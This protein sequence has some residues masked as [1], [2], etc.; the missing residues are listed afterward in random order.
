MLAVIGGTGFADFTGLEDIESLDVENAWG[1]ARLLR[2]RLEGERLLFLPRHGIPPMT[3]PHKINYRANIQALADAG[4]TKVVS[5]TAVGSVDA[6]LEVPHLVIPDQI[7][8]YTWGRSQ[9]FYD[10]EIQHIDFTFP[11]DPG[12]RGR[13]LEAAAELGAEQPD[14]PCRT[15]GVYGCTQGPRLET[16]A[17]IRRLRADGCDIVGMTAMPEAALARER[18]LPYAAMSIVVNAGAGIDDGVVDM[19]GIEGAISKG[20]TW[21]REIVRR[22]VACS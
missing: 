15:R 12:L 1:V 21:V 13:I 5:I 19:A 6:S 22:L 14:M 7:I 11:Y 18:D 4:A 8:D 3:P 20:M 9:T 16:A 2:G 10:D 17:E